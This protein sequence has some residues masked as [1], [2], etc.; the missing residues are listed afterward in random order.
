MYK[1]LAVAARGCVSGL[2][3]ILTQSPRDKGYRMHNRNIE[4]GT[5][6]IG[7]RKLNQVEAGRVTHRGRPLLHQDSPSRPQQQPLHFPDERVVARSSP[8]PEGE[9]APLGVMTSIKRKA[10]NP[11]RGGGP[12]AGAGAGSK[13]GEVEAAAQE[14]ACRNVINLRSTIQ[15]RASEGSASSPAAMAQK[16]CPSV[17]GE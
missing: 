9:R 13:D 12:E 14:N 7:A 16:V 2:G 8:G 4:E 15:R 17:Q 6:T 10:T 3:S 11:V 5:A 1:L